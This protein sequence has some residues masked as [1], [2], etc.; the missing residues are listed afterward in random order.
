[1]ARPSSA[2]IH[3]SLNDQPVS[4]RVYGLVFGL[5]LG[6][7]FLKF[8]NPP[9]LEHLS[10]APTNI[11]E[12]ALTSWPVRYAYPLLALLVIAG[13]PLVR[14]PSGLNWR[15][16]VLPLVWL[17][18][19]WLTATFS[20]DR[21]ISQATCVHFT[22]GVI[23]FYVGLLVA[24]RMVQPVYLG[25]GML[26]PFVVVLMAGWQQHFGGLEESQR[27]FLTYVAPLQERVEPELL[28]RMGNR[29]IFATL[30]YP[31]S[32][33][34]LLL[35][36]TPLMLGLVV[37]A[38]RQFTP[39]ARMALVGAV[40][41]GASSCLVWSGSKT[42]WL[43]ALAMG[44]VV[45]ARSALPKKLKLGVAVAL[46]VLGGVAFGVKY[47]GFFQRGA[48]S[49]VARFDYWRAALGNVQARPVTGSGPGTFVKVYAAVRPPEAE[50]ARLAHNDYLQQLSDSGLPGGG[51]FLAMVGSV[52]W[53]GRRVG[54][55]SDWPTFGV[56]LGVGFFAVQ[57]VVEFGF[58][59]PATAWCWFGLSG[60]LVAQ[61]GL[62]FDNSQPST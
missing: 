9:L 19:V 1:M 52:L 56:A 55:R 10:T 14:W 24:G 7:C 48:T 42:G 28:K 49:V 57:S 32:L 31:N 53:V 20:I 11:W 45:M 29:R 26:I 4:V 39:G 17:G 62:K 21:A 12:W 40:G 46:V 30:F 33:A 61:S 13:V 27:Y 35:L 59:V 50:M 36:L 38:R 47:H 25:L 23:C 54:W 3:G 44:V 60:W 37:A 58:Y 2:L 18:W 34:G 41:V 5:F 16:A 51:L 22:A 6:L 43:L 8:P 15:V